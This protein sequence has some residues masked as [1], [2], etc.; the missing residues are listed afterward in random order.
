MTR[1][2]K[3]RAWNKKEKVMEE[4]FYLTNTGFIY[5]IPKEVLEGDK[6]KSRYIEIEPAKNL[7]L[8]QYTGLKDKNGK[9]I[10]EGDIVGWVPKGSAG[11]VYFEGGRFRVEDFYMASFDE[12]SDAFGEGLGILEIIGNVYENQELLK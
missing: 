4:I 3:F 1:E 9:E 6:S 7:V 12:P 11:K 2:I 8:M 5:D 10:Y